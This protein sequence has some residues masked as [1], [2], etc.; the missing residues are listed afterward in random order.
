MV[1]YRENTEGEYAPVGGRLYQGSS[2]EV[3]I[4]T[5]IYTRRRMRADHARAAFEAARK[6]RK[7]SPPSPNPTPRF[8]AW[9]CGNEVF[10]G[11]FQ[12]LCG[13][14]IE[15]VTIDA[16]AMT[17]SKSP[18]RLTWSW[19]SNLFGDILTDLSAIVTGSMGLAASGNINPSARF[20]ACSSRCMVGPGHCGEGD[21]E[22]IGGDSV[23]GMLLDS[24]GF[25]SK[26]GGASPG[27]ATVLK[28]KAANARPGGATRARRPWPKRYGAL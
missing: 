21:R 28:A 14:S 5:S 20:P 7:K 3:A 2:S 23:A 9:C 6:R 11:G 4:Q 17:L 25:R 1:V 8:T 22:S 15:L 16:A 10:K 24:F 12:G 27:R 18:S 19:P 13:R 26:R